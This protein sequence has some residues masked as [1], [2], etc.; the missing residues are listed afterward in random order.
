MFAFQHRLIFLVEN[1]NAAIFIPK[2]LLLWKC[3]NLDA[4]PL[5]KS[6][7]IS[8]GYSCDLMSWSSKDQHKS[9]QTARFPGILPCSRSTSF[10]AALCYNSLK[11]DHL[12]KASFGGRNVSETRAEER[13][14]HCF[15]C[16]LLGEDNAHTHVH[17]CPWWGQCMNEFCFVFIPECAAPL[18]PACAG[19]SSNTTTLCSQLMQTQYSP[20]NKESTN[21]NNF[22]KEQK[23]LW[24]KTQ[25]SVV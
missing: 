12:R 2:P 11:P 1:R 9:L 20:L 5:C 19:E 4:W 3:L 6:L 25:L 13:K 23:R 18:K 14:A 17:I 16:F 7:R 8:Q 24:V 15:F 10:A 22:L 21:N